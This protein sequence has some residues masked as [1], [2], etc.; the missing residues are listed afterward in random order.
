MSLF[1]MLGALLA[2]IAVDVPIGVALGLVAVA[3]KGGD[4]KLVSSGG[5]V[6]LATGESGVVEGD[7]APTRR[8]PPREVLLK[9][10]WPAAKRKAKLQGVAEPGTAVLINGEPASVAGDGSFSAPLTL[11]PG[12]NRV[13][14]KARDLH[15]R[16]RTL[17]KSIG[18]RDK[19]HVDAETDGLWKKQ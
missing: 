3:A 17:T 7:R 15:G 5:D 19:P 13:E 6:A 8:R 10:V 2:L 1:V 16:S 4:V 14:V 9:V 12:K 11:A 18:L